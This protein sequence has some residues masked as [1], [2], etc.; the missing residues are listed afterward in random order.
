M[1]GSALITLAALEAD[2]I[3]VS[4]GG[5]E[6]LLRP[7][8]A[9]WTIP[10]LFQ[11][12]RALA[13]PMPATPGRPVLRAVAHADAGDQLAATLAV[14]QGS[15]AVLPLDA[16]LPVDQLVARATALGAATLTGTAGMFVLPSD[17]HVDATGHALALPR[18][19][20]QA[21]GSAVWYPMSA[22]TA[23]LARARAAHPAPLRLGVVR[24]PRSAGPLV[25]DVLAPLLAGGAVILVGE[26][27]WPSAQL[28]LLGAA[29][30]DALV[31]YP[32]A[33]HAIATAA[34][35]R[36]AAD[37]P[38]LR[39]ITCTDAPLTA[40]LAALLRGA[41]PE[42]VLQ[43]R[44][45]V[46]SLAPGLATAEADPGGEGCPTAFSPAVGLDVHVFDD[47]GRPCPPGCAGALCVRGAELAVAAPT[48]SGWQPTGDRGVLDPDG[49]F[50]LLGRTDDQVQIAGVA[51][52]TER[53]AAQLRRGPGVDQAE[54]SPVRDAWGAVRLVAF[55]TSSV[56]PAAL[57][58]ELGR[59]ARGALDPAERPA[60]VVV[61]HE[62]PRDALG[63]PDRAALATL[64]ARA[65]AADPGHGAGAVK[66]D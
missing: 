24:A 10:A 2:L 60:R 53:V 28:D 39:R 47:D 55:V 64:A 54:V 26:L 29:G 19:A 21:E 22:V 49:R 31:A 5:A 45:G 25:F 35:D 33:L 42:A 23:L 59:Y 18:A 13:P 50:R 40:A 37:R 1:A 61:V 44:Y 8:G 30:A 4:G 17:G 20:R 36:T 11:R 48:A 14:W 56:S 3:E 41:F 62:L 6:V 32:E 7:R 34:L 38:E 16:T 27:A 12:A 58:A 65:L 51:V 15:D 52:H 63:R 57:N 43:S 9:P 66:A 46:A